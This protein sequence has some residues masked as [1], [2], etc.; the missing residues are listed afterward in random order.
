LRGGTPPVL[1][2]GVHNNRGVTIVETLVALVLLTLGLLAAAGTGLRVK[3]MLDRSA[4]SSMVAELATR[5]R[6]LLRPA[7]CFPARRSDG[8]ETLEQGSAPLATN[9]W[10]FESRGHAVVIR[11]IT[12]YVTRAGHSHSDT[13]ET[14]VLC[15]D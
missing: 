9:T 8:S 15:A 13:V 7:A 3:Q 10:S 14:A 1:A 6:E 4:R 11:V 12:Q 5:R 2:R